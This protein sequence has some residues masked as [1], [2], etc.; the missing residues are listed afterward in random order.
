MNRRARFRGAWTTTGSTRK[1]PRATATT[2]ARSSARGVCSA[3]PDP[4]YADSSKQGEGRI[5]RK[6]SW[7]RSGNARGA[8]PRTRTR[9][10]FT[11][12]LCHARRM[13]ISAEE[14]A[15]K[16]RTSQVSAMGARV[17]ESSALAY[18]SRHV[19]GRLSQGTLYTVPAIPDCGAVESDAHPAR[20]QHWK[21]K[22]PTLEG[23]GMGRMHAPE[24]QLRESTAPCE[25]GE[26][27]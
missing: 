22:E 19:S 23:K 2:P 27:A 4:C 12:G 21:E 17:R 7:A 26:A 16:K 13:R 11:T 8:R 1:V 24:R 6:A 9:S 18:P 5:R 3:R 14:R 15:T 25:C 20:N 10:K